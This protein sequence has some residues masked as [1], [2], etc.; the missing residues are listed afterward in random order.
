MDIKCLFETL[1]NFVANPAPIP[2]HRT[3]VPPH[4]SPPNGGGHV[5][6]HAEI[7]IGNPDNVYRGNGWPFL[8][9]IILFVMSILVLT[10]IELKSFLDFFRAIRSEEAFEYSILYNLK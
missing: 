3:L 1:L 9:D 8:K 7:S 10:Y 5:P 4:V 6:P 2:P